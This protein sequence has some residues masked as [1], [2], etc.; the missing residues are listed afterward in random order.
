MMTL[1]ISIALFI[2]VIVAAVFLYLMDKKRRGDLNAL[3]NQRKLLENALAEVSEKESMLRAIF[4]NSSAGIFICT[5]RNYQ[6]TFTNQIFDD[7]LGYTSKI[8][9]QT[10]LMPFIGEAYR[11]EARQKLSR[12][13]EGESGEL[14]ME[15]ILEGKDGLPCWV[16]LSISPMNPGTGD[17][18]LLVGVA[19]D[20]SERKTAEE[21]K[22][23]AKEMYRLLVDNSDHAIG[24]IDPEGKILFYNKAAARYH[25]MEQDEITGKY[26][27][28]FYSEED[29]AKIM[30][31]KQEAFQTQKVSEGI[32]RLHL[33]GNNYVV[34]LRAIPIFESDGSLEMIQTMG[35]DLTA[36]YDYMA[37]LQ[38]TN[39]QLEKI[40]E[41]LPSA[42]YSS[43]YDSQQ[44]IFTYEYLSPV[45]EDIT[46]FSRDEFIQDNSFFLKLIHPED[47]KNTEGPDNIINKGKSHN[48]KYRIKQKSGDIIHVTDS[49][50]IEDLGD[51]K[52]KITGSLS[53][54]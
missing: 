8:A 2:A 37:K 16:D 42:L 13:D 32:I 29:A 12:I 6:L 7:M 19:V 50:E 28:E 38:E 1:V 27:Q 21:Q 53:R 9:D 40:L 52:Y 17:V 10:L 47:L 33:L 15:L 5:A 34:K 30:E 44:K 54:S 41:K 48:L 14:R 43:T 35:Y 36:Q 20:I 31:I 11:D 46:G 24:L 26:F 3:Q 39:Q 45:I 4:N 51:G 25:G 18:K 49:F 22:E 23:S